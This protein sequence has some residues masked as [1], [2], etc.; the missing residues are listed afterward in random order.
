MED[1]KKESLDTTLNECESSNKKI[2]D[3]IKDWWIIVVIVFFAILVIIK[4]KDFYFEQQDL[5]LISQEVESLGQMGDFFGGTLNPILAFLS[6]CLLLITI[7][8]QS[9]ELKNSTE[10]LA[11]SS[12]ALKEQSKSLQLQNFENTFF[13]M[14]NLHNQIVKNI[15]L[16]KLSKARMDIDNGNYPVY[17]INGIPIAV[18]EDSDYNGKKALTK[19]FE[20]QNIFIKDNINGNDQNIIML[21]NKFYLE[22]A[23]LINHYFINT[24]EILNFIN[25]N[26]VLKSECE[27]TQ[28]KNQKFYSN[29]F[30]AQLS[31]S[32]LALLL[33]YALYKV[34]NEDL[35]PLLVKFEIMEHLELTLHYQDKDQ[36]NKFV[37]RIFDQYYSY[38]VIKECI[39]KT[40]NIINE[41]Y[42]DD[43][44][45]GSNSYVKKLIKTMKDTKEFNL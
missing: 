28:I 8:L 42:E 31:S 30:R 11:K 15:S 41:N 14:I 43:K 25:E 37:S 24:Y 7:K 9:K 38:A 20:I 23:E 45:F 22:Y 44:I 10:E 13:N 2:I 27:D 35:F 4:V 36:N 5:C 12:Q 6:F 19:L 39:L 21:F 17:T 3:F 18:K 33:M 26:N 40:R 1:K 29:I 32:E 34:N 16:V